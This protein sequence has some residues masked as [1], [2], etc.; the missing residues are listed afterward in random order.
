[1]NRRIALLLLR[2]A[3]YASPFIIVLC[4]FCKRL[5]N[6]KSGATHG[7]IEYSHGLCN[8]PCEGAVDAGWGTGRDEQ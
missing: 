4:M 8:P 5:L 7:E 3:V 1:M 2:D 6:V